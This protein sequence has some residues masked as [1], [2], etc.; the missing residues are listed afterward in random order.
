MEL[1]QDLFLTASFA[2]ILSFLVAKLVAMAVAGRESE[3]EFRE[4]ENAGGGVVLEEV[5]FEERRL[6]V[7]EAFHGQRRVEFVGEVKE[8]DQFQFEDKPVH[9]VEEIEETLPHHQEGRELTEKVSE[10]EGLGGEESVAVGLPENPSD[11]EEKLSVEKARD[12]DHQNLEN[13][14]VE[15]IVAES[16]TNDVVTAQSEELSA[17]AFD[18][19]KG[20]SEANEIK[21]KA[22]DF[23]REPHEAHQSSEK[24]GVEEIGAE[25]ATNDVVSG[26]PEEVRAEA[27]VA[28]EVK[29]NNYSDEDDWEGIEKSELDDDFTAA[30]KFEG[31]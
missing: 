2:L 25:S 13:R 6:K 18:E 3:A 16:A 4:C 5:S 10:E 20:K 12:F 1:I 19:A 31:R 29:F 8:V 30:V 11:G 27:H 22:T 24:R 21:L 26:Q 7:E 15:E 28:S 14:G 23:D 9:R 17:V